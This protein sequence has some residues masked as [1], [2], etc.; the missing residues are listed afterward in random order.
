MGLSP[1]CEEL[2]LLDHLAAG[3][4]NLTQPGANVAE[5]RAQRW[6]RGGVGGCEEQVTLPEPWIKLCLRPKPRRFRRDNEF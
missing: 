1:A 2:E 5:G 4:Q 3:V 6:W